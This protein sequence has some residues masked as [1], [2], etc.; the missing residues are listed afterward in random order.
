MFI[1]LANLLNRPLPLAHL[2][3]DVGALA[4]AHSLVLSTLSYKRPRLHQHLINPKL[5]IHPEEWIDPLLRSLFCARLGVD[6][7]SRLWDV[8]VFEGDKVLI[9]AAV[10]ILIR[11]EGNL[12]GKRD[13]ILE[14][15]GWP[16]LDLATG[17][18]KPSSRLWNVGTEEE[19][20][21][22]VRE[23]GKVEADG[24]RSPLPV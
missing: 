11:L 5:D 8:Y 7:V 23:A 20:M 22:A 9:R 15:L 4:R 3:P 21:R 14:V 12:Y 10:G 13:E 6:D 16:S 19:F 1:S 18:D 17:I 24:D 2:L